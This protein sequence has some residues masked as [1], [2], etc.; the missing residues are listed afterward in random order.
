MIYALGIGFLGAPFAQIVLKHWAPSRLVAIPAL[1][2]LVAQL[3]VV[4]FRELEH[5]Q[6]RWLV[7]HEVPD[8]EEMAAQRT[9]LLASFL[10]VNL[11]F[12]FADPAL[13][14]AGG[15]GGQL[16]RS[17]VLVASSA[18][19]ARG[20]RRSSDLYRRE[21]LSVS[22]RRQLQSLEPQL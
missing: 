4:L 11:F 21:S 7:G 2:V 14:L 9:R 15:V 3:S 20:W 18:W 1:L 5:L 22:L 13:G 6:C 10:A 19:L 12:W 16:V 17:L 8:A